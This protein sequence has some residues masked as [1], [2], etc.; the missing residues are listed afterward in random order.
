[1]TAY[2][3]ILSLYDAYVDTYREPDGSLP[4]MMQLK[5]IHTA[6][7]DRNAEAI[8]EGEPF[9]GLTREVARSAAHLHDSGRWEQLRR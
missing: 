4:E 6:F 3:Q 8:A 2:S 9:A 7:V 1:M 5:R